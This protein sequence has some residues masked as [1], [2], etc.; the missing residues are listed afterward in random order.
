MSEFENTSTKTLGWKGPIIAG[1][2][3]LALVVITML[4]T[5]V[6]TEAELEAA[7]AEGREIGR[8]LAPLFTSRTE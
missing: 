8:A 7:R 6:P 2:I 5:P 3:L 4:V 1:A